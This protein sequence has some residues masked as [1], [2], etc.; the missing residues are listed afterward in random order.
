METT[1]HTDLYGVIG[2]PVAHSLSPFLMNRAFRQNGINA[3]YLRFDVRPG[4]FQSAVAGLATLGARGANVTYPFKEQALGVV[5]VPTPEAR[6]IGAVNTLVFREGR[7]VGANT[8]AEGAVMA[9]EMFAGI[10]VRDR[11]FFIYG[12]GGSARAAASG[13]LRHGAAGVTFGLRSPDKYA[14][15]IEVLG[16]HHGP[17]TVDAVS[18]RDTAAGGVYHQRLTGADVVINATPLGMGEKKDRS[19]LADAGWIRPGQCY[20]DFVYHP[21]RTRFLSTALVA[22]A[23]ALGGV[24]LLVCQAVESFRQWTGGTFDVRPMHEAL[25]TAFPERTIV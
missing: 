20:F 17:R 19:P 6:R 23:T 22:G 12:G 11:R 7:I 15:D 9:L 16:D 21:G 10:P 14:A 24:T 1:R 2:F 25:E 8:D 13:L 3:V 4:S 5:D 18:L